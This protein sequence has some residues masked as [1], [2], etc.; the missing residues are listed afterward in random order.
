LGLVP[1]SKRGDYYYWA[2]LAW[3]PEYQLLHSQKAGS[4][5]P[6]G[7]VACRRLS[8][9]NNRLPQLRIYI[10]WRKRFGVVSERNRNAPLSRWV[11]GTGLC[12]SGLKRHFNGGSRIFPSIRRP[13]AGV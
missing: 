7:F 13:A 11:H 10:A 12:K 6:D 8:P 2:V 5:P 9:G 4:F 3:R 1:T